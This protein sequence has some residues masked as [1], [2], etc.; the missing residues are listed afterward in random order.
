MDKRTCRRVAWALKQSYLGWKDPVPDLLT[1]K[2]LRI[3]AAQ[4]VWDTWL[5]KHNAELEGQMR[6]LAT[7]AIRNE[8]RRW[9]SHCIVRLTNEQKWIGYALRG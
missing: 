8:E 5:G 7:W 3:E 2:V 9:G 1:T 4:L 6:L